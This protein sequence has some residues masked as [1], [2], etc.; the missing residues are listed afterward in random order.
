MSILSINNLF[1]TIYKNSYMKNKILLIPIFLLLF[2]FKSDQKVKYS[3][4]ISKYIGK[5]IYVDM[6][7]SWCAPCRKEIIKVKKTKEKYINSEIVFIYITMDLDKQICNNAIDKDGVI[8]KDKNYYIEDIE[9][10]S[11]FKEIKSDGRIPHF[12]IY[13]KKGELV[14]TN[15]P[16]PSEKDK[17]HK[18]LE[19]YL[20]E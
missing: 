14:N 5:V 10:D 11:K 1:I 9:K 13:N 6:W 2:S 19:K 15:A 16:H 17:L 7:A 4:I 12:L 20:K 8:E 3:N 18:E